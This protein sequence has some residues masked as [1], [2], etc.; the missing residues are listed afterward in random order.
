MM[1]SNID[2]DGAMFCDVTEESTLTHDMAQPK[3]HKS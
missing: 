2:S 3:T 1:I